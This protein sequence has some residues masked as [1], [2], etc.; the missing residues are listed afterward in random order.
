MEQKEKFA[1]E[2][3]REYGIDISL[4]ESNLKK[5]VTGRLE[6]LQAMVERVEKMKVTGRKLFSE[7]TA[8][9]LRRKRAQR[10][11]LDAQIRATKC[12]RDK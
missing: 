11:I 7:S 2:R 10:A 6:N 4:L 12:R 1:I 9:T 3:A 8:A 5:T